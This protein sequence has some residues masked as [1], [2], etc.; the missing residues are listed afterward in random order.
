MEEII[1]VLKNIKGLEKDNKELL[2]SYPKGVDTS[3]L[4][5]SRYA[6]NLERM[7]D[8]ALKALLSKYEYLYEDV[9][10]FLYEMQD[11]NRTFWL[12][13][14]TPVTIKEDEDYYNYLRKEYACVS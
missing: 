5:D 10:W 11:N 14:G 12:K 2:S 6:I 1:K 8:I 7:R 4:W 9:M 13:D 3:Y